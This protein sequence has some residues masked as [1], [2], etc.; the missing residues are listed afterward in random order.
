MTARCTVSV[1]EGLVVHLADGRDWREA[2]SAG[3]YAPPALLQDGFI[4]LSTPELVHLP[5]NAMYGN[6]SDLVLLWIDP[7]RVGAEIRYELPEPD[8]DHP[9][10]HLYGPLN[11]DAVIAETP[12]APWKQGAF[13]LP[14]RP[15]RRGM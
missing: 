8:G 14:P 12:L 10:P 15:D 5:A 2:K 11:L 4:H 13:E 6:V 7:T 9:F 3:E 1:V